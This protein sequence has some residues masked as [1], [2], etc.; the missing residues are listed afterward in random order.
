MHCWILCTVGFYALMDAMCWSTMC[1]QWMPCTDGSYA[2]VYTVCTSVSYMH[3]WIL[4]PPWFSALWILCTGGCYMHCWILSNG[5]SY[6]LRYILGI[7]GFLMC[8]WN[9][10][11]IRSYPT[12]DPMLSLI[13]CTVDSLCWWI[14]TTSRSCCGSDALVTADVIWLFRI[15]NFS[16]KAVLW[17]TRPFHTFIT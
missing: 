10:S 11:N 4:C 1:T 12:V 6:I 5:G 14:H 16:M 17:L 2:L 13:L 8:L 15:V 9:L 3:W 7:S